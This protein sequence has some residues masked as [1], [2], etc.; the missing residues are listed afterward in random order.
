[1]DSFTAFDPQSQVA[2]AALLAFLDCLN[3]ESITSHVERHGLQAIDPEAWYPLQTALDVMRDIAA[4]N[5]GAMFDF[6]S[7][8]LAATEYMHLPDGYRNL[9][10]DEALTLL[11]HVHQTNHRGDAGGY[12]FEMLEPGHVRVIARLPYPD[13]LIYGIMYGF[14]RNHLPQNT[15]FTVTYDETTPRRDEGGEA[16]VFHLHWE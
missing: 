13:D 11:N 15:F 8:G 16:T 3:H 6:V 12:A 2:G 1:M 5:G 14:L 9:A 7:L 10:I 4:Y